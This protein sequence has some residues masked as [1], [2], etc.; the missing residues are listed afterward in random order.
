MFDKSSLC[1][2]KLRTPKPLPFGGSKFR[3]IAEMITSR[4]MYGMELDGNVR[5]LCLK[6]PNESAVK[7]KELLEELENSV[8]MVDEL[9]Q[10]QGAKAMSQVKSKEVKVERRQQKEC[11][12]P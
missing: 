10:E 12:D 8:E 9:L 1:A 11:E 6:Y 5:M 4:Q 2:A 3:V 7:I